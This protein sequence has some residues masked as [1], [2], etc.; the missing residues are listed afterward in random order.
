MSERKPGKGG[1]KQRPLVA[2]IV[3]EIYEEYERDTHKPIRH[4][5]WSAGL[6]PKTLPFPLA[7][8]KGQSRHSDPTDALADALSFMHRL[9]IKVASTAIP[10][11]MG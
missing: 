4:Y 7:N 1:K 6:S 11:I 9:G 3:V 10:R 8:V 5:G 2:C